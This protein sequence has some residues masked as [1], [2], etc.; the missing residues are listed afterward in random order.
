[1]F[2]RI[3]PSFWAG[4]LSIESDSMLTSAE[5][6]ASHVGHAFNLGELMGL[7][8]LGSLLPLLVVWLIAVSLWLRMNRPVTASGS[9]N[10]T[11]KPSA[12]GRLFDESCSF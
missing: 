1:M 9:C 7:R 12:S 6:G 4:K 8:G 10:E 3:V 5:A 2:Q 11:Q